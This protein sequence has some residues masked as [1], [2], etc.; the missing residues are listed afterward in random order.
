[1]EFKVIIEKQKC[2]YNQGKTLSID[3]RI[4]M[5]KRLKNAIEINEN[6]IC[7]ALWK[8]LKKS[9]FESYETEIGLVLEELNLAIK[10][11]KSW[12]K[13]KKKRT[14]IMHFISS[15]YVY[16]EPYGV[17][18]IMSPWNY[19]F[20]LTMAP[21]IGAIAA[22]NCSMIKPSAHSINVTKVIEKIITDTFE[23]KFVA[24]VEPYGGREEISQL[25]K[26]KYDYIFFTGSVP[27]GKIIMENASKYL[28]PITLELGGK[29]PCIVD[30]DADLDIAARR[31]VWGKFLNA[32]QTCVAPDYLLVHKDVK[33]SLLEKMKFVI[34][35]FYGD[36]AMES[37]DFPRIITDKQYNRL[38][39]YLDEGNIICGG[40]FKKEEK[41]ISPTLIDNID[42]DCKIMQ[43]EIFGPIMPVLEFI[44]IEDVINI[45]QDKPK[46]LA[47][48]YFSK[49]KQSQEY[50]LN[51]TTSGGGCIN[52]TVIHVASSHI[53]FG[54]VGESGMGAYHGKGSFDVFTH[55]RSIVK[56]SNLIDIAFRYPPFKD[57]LKWL[58]KIM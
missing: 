28:T 51:R 39:S 35:D 24:V 36:N 45:L 23:E 49:N 54:G 16:P 21:L 22:G 7:E 17:V 33:N 53:T 57:K 2:F 42:W 3:F 25:L 20:Q 9:Q 10:K 27:V 37:K 26:E 13:P 50:V 46:P 56:K 52:D 29:S 12:A 19:P 44:S 18:L 11:L 55:Y 40:N 6:I 41:F 1:M 14:S 47:L 15:S 30:Y 32:G 5:L 58:K 4:D 43:D 38:V 48:Y 34:K 31:I 8:D